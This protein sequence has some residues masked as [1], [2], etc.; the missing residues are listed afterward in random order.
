VTQHEGVV[1]GRHNVALDRSDPLF[2]GKRE[3]LER[4]F[5]AISASA[6]VAED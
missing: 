6:A 3:R 4:V 5:W 1:F 2:I